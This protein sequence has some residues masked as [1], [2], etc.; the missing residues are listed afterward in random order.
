MKNVWRTDNKKH[1]YLDKGRYIAVRISDT[2]IKF[3][4][5]TEQIADEHGNY[6]VTIYGTMVI[7]SRP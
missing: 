4:P 2:R 5:M 3:F 7:R 1:A 6:V